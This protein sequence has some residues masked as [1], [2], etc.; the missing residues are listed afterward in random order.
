MPAVIV[1]SHLPWNFS[2]GRPQQLL[3]RLA[4]DYRIVFVEEPVCCED[5]NGFRTYSP[6][7][8]VEV[9]Q[10]HTPIDPGGCGGS[11]MSHLRGMVRQ[12]AAD[13]AD[14]IAWFYTPAA[15]PLLQ[16]LRPRLVV[17]DCVSELAASE[18]AWPRLPQWEQAMLEAADIV[19]TDGPSLYRTKR[20][21]HRNAHCVPSGVDAAHFAPAL[22]RSNSHAAH[23]RIPGPR[24]GFCGVID[25][26][27]DAGLVAHVADAHPQWQIVLVTSTVSSDAAPL[28]TRDNIH[29]L[30]QQSH[31]ALPYFLA[32]WDVC[33]LP[34]V[35]DDSTRFINPAETLAYMAAE[36]P[37]VSTPLA[38]VTELYG[39]AVCIAADGPAFV[40]ACEAA[41]L[42]SPQE[43]S[44]KVAKMRRLVASASWQA[45]AEKIRALIETAFF[46][47]A[48]AATGTPSQVP[49]DAGIGPLRA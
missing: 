7:P 42:A 44:E 10:P 37:V 40:A 6:A 39:E 33:L 1:F 9:Y 17:Y 22:D 26:R 27:F 13:H 23:R 38:D 30:G 43:R 14:H 8:N 12:L 45:A 19:L 28:P 4:K 34:L 41:L 15:L 35:V 36:L 2:N 25:R 48:N 18:H 11:R 47:E 24:L 20:E 46:M 32:G 31:A 16:E 3:T 29:Y 5:E 21:R 49:A